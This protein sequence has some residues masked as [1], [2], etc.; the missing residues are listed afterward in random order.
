MGKT[1]PVCMHHAFWY[2]SLL[3]LHDCDR[4]MVNFTHY[5]GHKQ[6]TSKISFSFYTRIWFLGIRLKQSLL[7][8]AVDELFE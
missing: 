5:G 1:T 3:S 8:F 4:K 6:T 2:I 7:V